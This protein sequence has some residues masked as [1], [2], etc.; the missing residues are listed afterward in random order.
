MTEP[1]AIKINE[2]QEESEKDA[3]FQAIKKGIYDNKWTDLASP[4]KP[5]TTELCFQGNI[6][7]RGTRM[8]I[9]ASLQ[10]RAMELAHEGHPGMSQMKR[11]LRSK[12]WWPKMD[13][14]IEQFVKQC[15]G[16]TLVSAPSQPEPM[17]RKEL[18]SRPWEHL[19]MDFL[20]PLPS[21]H[22]ILVLVDY[23]SRFFEIEI[24]TKIDSKATI[25]RL[26][27]IF[28]RFGFPLSVTA[29]NGR[30]FKK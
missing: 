18:P 1:R 19:A 13:Q 17:K 21:G 12:S 20:G 24:M 25:D 15:V 27:F 9:P 6:L 28:A 26:K 29:D 16:C 4:F 14:Q 8:Y 7:L 30:Q 3:S 10:T 11:R 5:F 22:H 2:I 23:F